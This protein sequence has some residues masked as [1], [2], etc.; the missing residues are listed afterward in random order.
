MEIVL[1]AYDYLLITGILFCLGALSLE[2]R[3]LRRIF[4]GKA[5]MGVSL[6]FMAMFGVLFMV[7]ALIAGSALSGFITKST[8][9][10]EVSSI[11]K[12]IGVNTERTLDLKTTVV[13]IKEN[14]K[15]ANSIKSLEEKERLL[16]DIG[17]LEHRIGRLVNGNRDLEEDIDELEDELEELYALV[18][19]GHY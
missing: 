16:N 3:V 7:T 8:I 11:S 5:V 2:I 4:S 12:K 9:S 15:Q 17:Q 18:P 10:E 6:K 19:N 14:I 1:Q 13:E